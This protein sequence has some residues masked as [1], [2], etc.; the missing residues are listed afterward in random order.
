MLAVSDTGVGMSKETM[1]HMFEPFFTT[2]PTGKGTG[3]GLA[4]VYGIVRQTGAHISVK[5][6][7]GKG[8]T[9]RVY[10][11]AV[12]EEATKSETPPLV[13]VG[14]DEVILV[15]EDENLVRR[16][17]CKDLRAAGYTVL[18]AENGKH[19]LEVAAGYGDKIDLL[20]SDVI[21]PEMNGKQLA[22]AMIT[23][24]PEM[25]IVFISG[26]TDD[27]LDGEVC[28]GEGRDF[29]QKPFAPKDLLRRVRNLLDQS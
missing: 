28:R 15:C 1:E 14:G 9:I 6:E 22:E 12:E 29:L 23:R 17:V 5:S 20:V 27:V 24:Y 21:M 4:T 2:K 25:R 19:A 26:Y 3:L 7:L 10:F 16:G 13:E 11:P 18:E 8:S